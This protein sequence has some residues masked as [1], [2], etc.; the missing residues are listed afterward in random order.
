MI[1]LLGYLHAAFGS[2]RPSYSYYDPNSFSF[3]QQQGYLGLTYP[4]PDRLLKL[5]FGCARGLFFASPV[6]LAAAPVG[7]W[8]LVE[9]ENTSRRRRNRG[10][11]RF[12]LLPVQRVVLLVESRADIRAALRGQRASRLLCIGLAVAWTRATPVWRRV[13]T[14]F[15][16]VQR[17]RSADG[18]VNDFATFHAGQLSAPALGL[19]GILV[20]T[21]GAQSRIDAHGVGSWFQRAVRSIQSWPVARTTG[22]RQSDP[23]ACSLGS[24]GVSLATDESAI[25]PATSKS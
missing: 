10:G 21:D 2:W 7:L 4:H 5:L 8:C 6:L 23:A 18:G 14:R 12:V 25:N 19:A 11:D 22:A 1:V 9:G 17:R 24:C 15:A 13:L 16:S 20:G 3:M